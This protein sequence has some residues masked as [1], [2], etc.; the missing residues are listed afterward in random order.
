MMKMNVIALIACGLFLIVGV[1]IVDDYGLSVDAYAQR[2]LAIAA[3][4]YVMGVGDY[5]LQSWTRNYG[6]A[7]EMVLLLFER[8]MGLTDSRDVYLSRHLLTHLFFLSGGFFCSLLVYRLFNSRL[9]ALFALLLFLLHPRMYAHSFFNSKDLPFLSMFMI[10]LFLIHRAFRK[11][12]TGAFLLCGMGI[13]ILANMRIIGVMLFPAVLAMRV[14]DLSRASKREGRTHVLITTTGFVLAS[15]LTLYVTW[16][17]L[18]TDPVGRFI[19]SWVE[20]SNYF[21]Y[22]ISEQFMGQSVRTSEIPPHYTPVWFSIT[23]PPLVLLLGIIGTGLILY[24][25][26]FRPGDVLR[27]TPLRFEFLLIA[28]IV[29]PLLAVALL[30]STLYTGARQMYFLYAPICLLALFGLHWLI[31]V[32]AKQKPFRMGVYVMAGMSIVTMLAS[33]ILLHPHQQMYFNFLVDRSTPEHLRT[34]YWMSHWGPGY[35]QILEHLLEQYPTS[36]I[37]YLDNY[38]LVR[39]ARMLLPEADRK[40]VFLGTGLDGP[41]FTNRILV[42]KH[43]D[44]FFAYS[45]NAPGV[46]GGYFVGSNIYTRKIYNNTILDVG[47]LRLSQE[48]KIR[49]DAWRKTYRSTVLED[50]FFSSI[51]DVYHNEDERTLVYI[52]ESCRADDLQPAFLLHVYP[53]DPNDL[54][55]EFKQYGFSEF[56]FLFRD[57]GVIFDGKCVLQIDLPKY[58]IAHIATGQYYPLIARLT[59]WVY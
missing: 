55:D 2:A 19:D 47:E 15:M 26:I 1:V 16:P 48:G 33:I 11:D 44:N 30:G 9:L 31:S 18:W 57:V 42:G 27:N 17:Y 24:R 7:F 37:Y 10:D 20:M 45:G 41:N 34:Q 39:E 14:C 58:R 59:W 6:V 25:G 4:D 52:Q 49:A 8:G 53:E 43:V 13:G 38:E 35:L 3:A 29:L 23:T 22:N 50:P 36:N 40:R 21:H 5:Y 32:S 12:T 28:C 56:S 51:F 54:P 46:M